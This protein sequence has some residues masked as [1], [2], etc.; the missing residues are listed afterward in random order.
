[1]MAALKKAAH[2]AEILAILRRIPLPHARGI[3]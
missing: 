1:M 3:S 2:S